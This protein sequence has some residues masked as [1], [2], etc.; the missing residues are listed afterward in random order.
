MEVEDVD[1]IQAEALEAQVDFLEERLG[2]RFGRKFSGPAVAGLAL[3]LGRDEIGIARPA[4]DDLPDGA[5]VRPA[6]VAVGRVQMDDT[7]VEGG[8][9]QVFVIGVHHSHG[10]DREL[11]PGFPERPD[12]EVGFVDGGSGLGGR[13]GLRPSFESGRDGGESAGAGDA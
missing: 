7:A 11:D 8:Q 2:F 6:L 5:F 1:M 12:D 4:L 13:D 9:D 10:N 3:D